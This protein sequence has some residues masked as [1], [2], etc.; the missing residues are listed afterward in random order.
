M[1][2][3]QRVAIS[4]GWPGGVYL[5]CYF[6]SVLSHP[7]AAWEPELRVFPTLAC[8]LLSCVLDVHYYY[9]SSLP[10][11]FRS[12]WKSFVSSCLFLVGIMLSPRFRFLLRLVQHTYDMHLE[13]YQGLHVGGSHQF[14]FVWGIRFSS[15]MYYLPF[16]ICFPPEVIFP[17]RVTG[18][19][20]VTTDCIVATS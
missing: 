13:T 19:C 17:S 2:I 1:Q 15:V 4:I 16:F 3:D 6:V 11:L 20:P 9:F 7:R 18:A 12:I 5:F 14:I 8:C 10:S